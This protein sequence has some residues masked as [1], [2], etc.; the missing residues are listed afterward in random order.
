M[1]EFRAAAERVTSKSKLKLKPRAEFETPPNTTLKSNQETCCALQAELAT[2]DNDT[3]RGIHFFH[4][5][6]FSLNFGLKLQK[7][8]RTLQ[9]LSR[10]ATR[11]VGFTLAP[12]ILV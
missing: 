8:E 1:C 11:S 5:G 4:V 12:L 6:Y 2:I 3:S 9:I 7:L 10:D